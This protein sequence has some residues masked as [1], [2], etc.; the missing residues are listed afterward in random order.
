MFKIF[1]FLKTKDWVY[2]GLSVA[3]I[4]LQVW[5]EITM[6]E[7]TAKLSTAVS[8][9]TIE[10]GEVW[11]NG[12]L[13]IA[14]AAGSM[15]AALICG[16]FVS[17]VAADFAKTLREKLFGKITS[18]GDEEINRFSTPSLITRTTND[19]VQ[20]QM[21]IAM[22]LQVA[23]KAPVMA[24][25]AICKI[26]AS[27]IQWTLAVVVTVVVIVA[28]LAIIVGLC[29]PKFKK[30]QKLTDD[31]NEITRENIGGVRV[32]RAYNA[33]EY[34]EN[35]FEKVNGAVTKNNLFTARAMGFL[36]P[37]LTMCMS[38]LSLALYW[39]AAILINDIQGDTMLE[40]VTER[41]QLIGDMMAF[42]QYALQV[43]GAF[44]MLIMIFIILPRTL[45]SAKRINEV[46][47]TT[48][49]IQYPATDPVTHTQGEIEFKDVSFSYS[50]G[51]EACIENISFKIN[52]GETFAVIGATGSGKTTLV[53]LIPR[54][55]DVTE[56][57]ILVDGVNVKQYTKETLQKKVSVAPQ[58]A[59]LFK[60][61]IKSNVTYGAQE[62]ISDDDPRI[63]RA[64]NVAKADFVAESEHGI[65]TE[66]AQGGTNFSGGQKQRLSIARAVFKQSEIMIF[67]DTFSALDY[68]T[69]MLVRKGIKDNLAGTTVIIVAQ[70][71]GT[72]KN[73]DKILVLDKGKIAGLGKHEDLILNCPVYRE[74]ALSQLSKEEL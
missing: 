66:V 54:F 73:A 64:L 15:A 10:M 36:T 59:A 14:C 28:M 50:D 22:G 74:I 72:I 67:D 44:M 40:T 1:K 16:W 45:V 17:N 4:V 32:I 12:G 63:S 23:V 38:G 7:Y 30:I 53:N 52:Q 47:D 29:Y 34:Q 58:K 46:L 55:Y 69:D 19:V 31:L 49:S 11:K 18:F 25:W 9:N 68:K 61:D 48:P 60:G 56:G 27:N 71:I 3:L 65:H 20:M 2:I 41:A 37:V 43:V 57:E 21:L 5:L 35:K 26:S 24:V 8:A 70:R 33:E 42:S 6:P 39:I 51:G 13:M 62:E